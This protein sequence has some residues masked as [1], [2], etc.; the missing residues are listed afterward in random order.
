M[1]MRSARER[2]ALQG[3][4]SGLPK[5]VAMLWPLTPGLCTLQLVRRFGRQIE[6]ESS[7]LPWAVAVGGEGA[8]GF[9]RGERGAVQ[10]EAVAVLLR[11]KAV[12]EDAREIFLGDADAVVGH[13]NLHPAVAVD[14]DADGDPLVAPRAFAHRVLGVCE[15]R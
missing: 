15:S 4:R 11:G 10:A 3:E 9:R 1:A 12:R 14:A 5:D 8:A 7:A 13:G 6:R 2:Q